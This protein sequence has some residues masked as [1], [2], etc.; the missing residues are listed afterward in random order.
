M[1]TTLAGSLGGGVALS[2]G[3]V[4]GGLL[5]VVAEEGVQ[6]PGSVDSWWA[7]RARVNMRMTV[8]APAVIDCSTSDKRLLP[9]HRT[10]TQGKTAVLGRDRSCQQSYHTCALGHTPDEG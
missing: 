10:H 1:L 2:L 6:D 8:S 5:E 3:A 4:W 7:T 9:L